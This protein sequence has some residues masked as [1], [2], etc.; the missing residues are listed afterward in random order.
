MHERPFVVVY[1]CMTP[2]QFPWY[3][4]YQIIVLVAVRVR[5]SRIKALISCQTS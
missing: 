5:H 1:V 3:L 2:F 4:Q